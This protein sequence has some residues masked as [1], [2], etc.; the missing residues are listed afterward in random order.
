MKIAA[1]IIGILILTYIPLFHYLDVSAILMWDEA[2]YANNALEMSVSK[3]F[4]ILKSNGE[5]T[6]YNVKPPLVIWLQTFFTWIFGLNELAIRLPS[7]I[8]GF[9]TCLAIFF[10]S[11]KNLN[12]SI[13]FIAILILVTSQ[14]YIREHVTRTGD[15]DSVL[16]FFITTYTLLFWD[17]LINSK[18]KNIK[19][20][21]LV[22]ALVFGAFM[23]KS[24][25]GLMPLLGLFLGAVFIKKMQFTISNP[26]IYLI[27]ISTLVLCGL[28]YVIRGLAVDDGYLDKVFFSEYSRFTINIMPY[29]EKP[30]LFYWNN[31]V[32]KHFPIYIYLLILIPINWWGENDKFRKISILGVVF[33]LT[34]FLL[35]SYPKVKLDWYD[36]PL[37]PILSLLIAMSLYQLID[38][39]KVKP[40]VRTI[41]LVIIT[42]VL[43]IK[44]YYDVYQSNINTLPKITF[45]Y[46]GYAIKKM[47]KRYPELSNCKVL[48]S[49]EHTEHIDQAN[50]YVKALNIEKDFNFE[51]IHDIHALKKG[52]FVICSQPKNLETL[53]QHFNVKTIDVFYK[54]KLLK[55]EF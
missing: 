43:V 14:G 23:S 39:L 16:V 24:V 49:V 10:F 48:M 21:A 31:L 51:I 42:T 19:Q 30:F 20:L 13:G 40:I 4:L 8:A 6:L 18:Q 55:V 53:N 2:I 11:K 33:C 34:Y 1:Y 9:M 47:S 29:H 32:T 52:D 12:I 22:G 46:D 37:F 41:I 5:A 15:L 27:G 54:S 38:V 50:F 17:Y 7:A 36:A 25:V 44:P 26:Q 35:I 28:Y 45:E 3:D